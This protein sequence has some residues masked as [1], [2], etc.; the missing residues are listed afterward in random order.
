MQN[1]FL[2]HGASLMLDVVVCALV[3]VL[4][5]LAWSVWLVKRRRHYSQHR[6]VQIALG[7]ALLLTVAAFEVD[8]QLVHDGWENVVRRA[9]G[10]SWMAGPAFQQARIVLWIHLVFAVS[11]PVLW[12]VTTVLALRRFGSPPRPG[13]HSRLHKTLAWVS[14]ADLTL[15]SL[16]GLAF[17]YVAF[18]A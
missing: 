10:D 17:Y 2:G 15:T 11:T 9:R 6:N 18:V 14:V 7:A 3:L 1:G 8:L 4:P 12:A 5:A 13:A 16:T